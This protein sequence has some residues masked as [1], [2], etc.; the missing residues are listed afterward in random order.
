MREY[1]KLI[2]VPFDLTEKCNFTIEI[3]ASLTYLF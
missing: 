2:P 3:N 1:C